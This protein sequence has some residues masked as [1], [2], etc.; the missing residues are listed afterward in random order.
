MWKIKNV[1]EHKKP[2]TESEQIS[3][4]DGNKIGDDIHEEHTDV[5]CVKSNENKE[6]ERAQESYSDRIK[7]SEKVEKSE[8]K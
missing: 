7:I 8:I 3:E 2:P 1:K 4:K 6:Y 5:T